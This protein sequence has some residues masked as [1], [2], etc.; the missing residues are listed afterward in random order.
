MYKHHEESIENM[1]EHYRGDAEIK[2]LF[3]IGSV[4]TGT[5]R[6]NSDLDA[7]GVVSEEH[8]AKKGALEVYRGKCTYDDGGYFDMHYMTRA[9]LEEVLQRGSEPMR[10][11]F[12]CAR[13]LYCREP[14]LADLIAKIPVFQKSE[15][16]EKQFRFYCTMKMFHSY[17]WVACKPEGFMRFHVAAGII[18]NLYRLILVENEILF[19]SVRKLEEYAIRAPNKPEN[20]IEKCRQLMETLS[21]DACLDLVRSYEAWTSYDYP[22]EHHVVMNNF[23]DPYDWG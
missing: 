20:I 9:K 10:N 4:A 16:A 11:M 5:A 2:A 19:P 13:E 14:G 17:F 23:S 8:Y 7:V 12:S 22:K 3:L 21:D 15:A 6:A 1:I 18:Y